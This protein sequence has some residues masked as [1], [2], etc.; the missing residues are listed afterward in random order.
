MGQIQSLEDLLNFLSRRLWLIVAVAALGTLIAAFVAKSRPDTYEAAALIQVQGAQVGG[1]PAAGGSAQ[2]LQSIEQR[3]TTRD[4]LLAVIERHDLYADLPGLS[5]DERIALL[6]GSITFQS[7]AAAGNQTY[8]APSQISAII[9]LARDGNPEKAARIANDFAQGMLDL[10]SSGQIERARDT[11]AFYLEERDRAAVEVAGLEAAIAEYKNAN[12]QALL[13]TSAAWQDELLGIDT[14]IRALD[15][16]LV[17]LLGEQRQLAGREDLR[18]T[19]R[20][21]LAD[22][23]GEIAVLTD[24]KAALEA[25]RNALRTEI[26]ALPEVEADLAAMERDLAAAQATL[27]SATARLT[28]AETAQ[29]LAERQQ[30]ER[31]ALLDRA[32]T[33]EYPLG[34]SGRKLFLAGAVG[35]V[36]AGLA[37]ALILDLARPVVRTTAQMERQ[38]GL[39]PVIAIPPLDLPGR[40]SARRLSLADLRQRALAAPRV[41]VISG[42]LTLVL[43]TAAAFS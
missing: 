27:A 36:L 41:L 28:E 10:S 32:V 42:G 33:P 30:G 21:R 26:A 9:V 2:L 25:R 1:D 11:Y 17:A 22:L 13:G 37:L 14:E 3:L 20:R 35:S 18:S 31:F 12:S 23:D 15:Q 40:P 43:M 5:L 4:A 19:E 34:S 7:I 29:R 38:L 24:Q 39:R 6:R 16:Q 8:G